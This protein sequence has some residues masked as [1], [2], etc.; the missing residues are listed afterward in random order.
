MF[1]IKPEISKGIV[2]DIS[3]MGEGEIS[4]LFLKETVWQ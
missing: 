1:I 2:S 3:N 4:P